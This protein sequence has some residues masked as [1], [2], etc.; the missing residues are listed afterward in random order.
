MRA[1]WTAVVVLVAFAGCAQPTPEQQFVND[2]ATALGGKAKIDTTKGLDLVGEGVNYNLGQDLRPGAATQTFKVT[3][4]HR[5]VDLTAPRM[6]IGQ[7]RTPQF[8]YFQGPQ[9]QVQILGLDADGGYNANAA[10]VVTRLAAS[11][12]ADRKAEVYHHPLA[13]VKA[14]LAP[15]AKISNVSTAGSERKA[16]V[17][18]ADGLTFT[19]FADAT[20]LPQRIESKADQP[21]LGDVIISTTFANYEEVE[22]L[23]LPARLTT[24]TD[25]FTT[26]EIS[27]SKQ[28]PLGLPPDVAAHADTPAPA[29]AAAPNVTVE[30]LAKGVWF[31]AGQSHHSV[32][33]EFTDH[34]VLIEAPQSEARSLAVIAKAR[35]TV[36]GK[37][38]TTLVTTHHHFDH[39][40]GLRAAI[41]EGL[42][43]ITQ[44]GNKAF[45]ETMAR[46]PHTIQPDALAKNPKPVTV[47]TVDEELV[48]RDPGT[49][50]VEP[51]VQTKGAPYVQ[52]VV[53]Y[54]V[55]GNPHSDTMLMAYLP[56]EKILVEVDAFTPGSA[57]QPYAANL[58][59]NITSRKLKID[60]I[61][62]LH[63]AIAKFEEL[64]KA[65]PTP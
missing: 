63:G 25:D 45:V 13:M 61:V 49:T 59:E 53:L 36:P 4:Y 12:T 32:L 21:N 52:S 47:E 37:P 26:A 51:Y 56:N 15:T 60:R 16:D 31:L 57:V 24:R 5:V 17:T 20:G 41:S 44:A 8:A 28:A 22:G 62:P 54:H 35:E 38:L 18:V 33:L 42:T 64:Q 23:K 46:R 65:V 55:K 30:P 50:K 3:D 11:A 10:G 34:L 48:L 14:A 1:S 6:R 40:A 9:A 58:L 19:V 29:A 27:L 43:V 7:T 39:T 2:M